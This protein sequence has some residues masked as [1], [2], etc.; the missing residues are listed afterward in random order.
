MKK[1]VFTYVL[2]FG[3]FT[4]FSQEIV[5]LNEQS[6]KAEIWDFKKNKDW[7]YR[8]EIPAVI[9]FYASWCKPC[10][11]VAPELKTLK[12]KYKNKIRIYEVDFDKYEK[13]AKLF[14]IRT[15]PTIIYAKKNANYKKTAGYKKGQ[16]ESMMNNFLNVK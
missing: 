4:V 5:H 9:N 14:G 12:K 7:K 15:I 11:L 10:K 3:F 16:I 8:G 6:F 13:L 2:M 1:I